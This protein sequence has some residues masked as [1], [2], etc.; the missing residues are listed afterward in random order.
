MLGCGP[1]PFDDNESRSDLADEVGDGDGDGDEVGDGDGD[2]DGDEV[3]DGDGDG[4]C[5][6]VEVASQE[7]FV[8]EDV[9]DAAEPSGLGRACHYYE[10]PE[11]TLLWTAP[12]SGDYRMSL[13]SDALA[14]TAGVM[15]KVCGGGIL[16]CVLD[17]ESV[18]FEAVAGEPYTFVVETEF[19]CY[20]ELTVELLP[21]SQ[22]CQLVD[23]HGLS[24]SWSGMTEGI[25][26]FSSECGGEDSSDRAW[27][28]VPEVGGVYRLATAGSEFDTV[29]Y[30]F[31]GECSGPTI[32]CNN[33]NE[34]GNQ[35]Q[36]EVELQ[37][38]QPYTIVIDGWGG[39][40]GHYEFTLDWLG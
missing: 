6:Q 36:L 2:G 20:F 37:A 13:D 5:P 27:L 35:A 12:T 11:R 38:G 34:F 8:F 19:T 1:G 33:D 40:N 7:M 28:F 9:I 4:E 24:D 25:S 10:N 32:A 3:G 21:P 39:Q 22:E 26:E 23:L 15:N 30:V 29:L 16:G 31:D 14:V 18:E 17:G